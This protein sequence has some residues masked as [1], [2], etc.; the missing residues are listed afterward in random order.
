MANRVSL[1]L[2]LLKVTKRSSDGNHSQIN[3]KRGKGLNSGSH[4]TEVHHRAPSDDESFTAEAS[5]D[6]TE[7]Y[8]DS[9]LSWY[10]V[11]QKR[12]SCAWEKIRENLRVSYVASNYFNPDECPCTACSQPSCIRCT[13]CG[14][15]VFY[16]YHSF[17]EAHSRTNIFHIG[18]ILEVHV[19]QWSRLTSIVYSIIMLYIIYYNYYFILYNYIYTII[20]IG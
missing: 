6:Q 5:D 17:G 11:R 20:I 15:R 1:K 14:P 16:Y 2:P 10:D 3:V 13:E 7:S 9:T 8:A 4:R 19:H 12:S 18:E